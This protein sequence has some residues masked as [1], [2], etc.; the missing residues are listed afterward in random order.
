WPIGTTEQHGSHLITGLDLR[1]AEAV[2][3]RAAAHSDVNTILLPG[4]PFGASDHWLP[5]GATIS[6]RP[7]TLVAVLTDG[8]RSIE[9]A[10]FAHLILLNG[11]AG[12]IGPAL[13]AAAA[14][15]QAALR[16]EVCSYWQL[17]DGAELAKRCSVDD[18][19]VGHAGEVETSI[20]M[21]LDS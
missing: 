16:V 6:I 1:A 21:F 2:A 5:L 15:S 8:I 17:V 4:L 14:F 11:H 12:N 3:E 10:G 19:G 18:G 7:E 9:R 13:A 20:A